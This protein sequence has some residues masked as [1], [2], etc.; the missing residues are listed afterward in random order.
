MASRSFLPMIVLGAIPRAVSRI[1]AWLARAFA[2]P[3]GGV[4]D[5]RGATRAHLAA[6]ESDVPVLDIGVFKELHATLGSNT[7]RVRN[8]YAK[9]LKSAAERIDEL[10]HQPAAASLTTL[11]AL[12]GSA[13][14]IG[15]TRLANLAARLHEATTDRETLAASIDDIERELT[16]FHG[17]LNAQLDA[18]SGA[19]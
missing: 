14:M 1:R 19:R 8:V 5:I 4:L 16:R 12:K 3:R 6:E 18:V 2:R 15:A 9:F 7:D 11:H 13:G 17:V 10:R